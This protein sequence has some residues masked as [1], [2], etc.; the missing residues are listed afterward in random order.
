MCSVTRK[1]RTLCRYLQ[2]DRSRPRKNFLAEIFW[3]PGRRRS[4]LL[5]PNAATNKSVFSNMNRT[6]RRERRGTLSSTQNTPCVRP[7]ACYSGKQV[8]RRR[9]EGRIDTYARRRCFTVTLL[10]AMRANSVFENG[11]DRVGMAIGWVPTRGH[12]CSNRSAVTPVG[13]KSHPCLHLLS[14]TPPVGLSKLDVNLITRSWQIEALR[15][16]RD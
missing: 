13:K 8:R 4:S 14:F 7:H 3:P 2:V 5:R 10:S 15:E 9:Q 16:E 6:L 11:S 1:T 12:I